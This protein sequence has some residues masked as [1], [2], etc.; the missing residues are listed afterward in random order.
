MSTDAM[1]ADL[2]AGV[3]SVAHNHEEFVELVEQALNHHDPALVE[4]RVAVAKEYSWEK[5][6]RKIH[7]LLLME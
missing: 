6:V 7:D 3:V 4:H 1:G 2:F 5:K